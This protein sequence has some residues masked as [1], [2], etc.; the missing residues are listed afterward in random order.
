MVSDA[1]GAPSEEVS[2]GGGGCHVSCHV[3]CHISC[4]SLR[5]PRDVSS[6]S[7]FP[8]VSGVSGIW[9]WAVMS[10]YIGF[11]DNAFPSPPLR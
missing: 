9:R 6:L 4:R 7:L 11:S 2:Q 3:S 10:S 5:A 8:F 1:L